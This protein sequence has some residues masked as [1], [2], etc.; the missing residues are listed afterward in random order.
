MRRALVAVACL[1]ALG[2]CTGGGDGT[3]APEA[4]KE[5][6]VVEFAPPSGFRLDDTVRASASDHVGIRQS[7]VDP[8]GRVLHFMSGITGE[9]GEGEPEAG[10]YR[11]AGGPEARLLGS[12]ETWTLV[13]DAGGRCSSR[14]VIGNGLHRERF[15]TALETAGVIDS[16]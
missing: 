3:P 9:F 8:R 11:V 7:Y 6:C 5:L 14:A 10:S 16:G 15:L 13:W 4:S 1:T 2:A 12:G